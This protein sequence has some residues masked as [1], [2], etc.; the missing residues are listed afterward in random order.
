MRNR[1]IAMLAAL[2]AV[3]GVGVIAAPTAS[4]S[5][6]WSAYQKCPFNIAAWENVRLLIRTDANGRRHPVKMQVTGS[7]HVNLIKYVDEAKNNVL[8]DEALKDHA[9]PNTGN[10][11]TGEF[12]MTPLTPGGLQWKVSLHRTNG[13]PISTCAT[14]KITF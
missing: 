6:T 2:A 14:G 8:Q 10:W 9:A 11:T 4:A 1:I 13:L 5:D 12:A 7:E 3:L